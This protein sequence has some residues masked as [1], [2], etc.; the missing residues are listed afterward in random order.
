MAPPIPY[1]YLDQ[2]QG[3]I[4]PLPSPENPEI[5]SIGTHGFRT[6]V[7][8]YVPL[9]AHKCFAAHI[10]GHVALPQDG[11][12]SGW[13]PTHEQ[14]V[15]LKK[16]MKSL[17]QQQLPELANKEYAEN[18]LKSYAVVVCPKRTLFQAGEEKRATGSYIVEAINEF[19]CLPGVKNDEVTDTAHGFV[20][21]HSS[22][23]VN[24]LNFSSGSKEQLSRQD[25]LN[26]RNDL[27]TIEEVQLLAWNRIA[28]E[29]MAAEHGY[30][31]VGTG[32]KRKWS[33][34]FDA[35]R[36]WSILD[37]GS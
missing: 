21:D 23:E 2:G 34:K 22:L 30:A 36:G 3:G 18:F 25:Q 26:S 15:A 13:I 9:A 28:I 16:F 10:D 37:F 4:F 32:R 17:L 31:T 1:L 7:C 6:C 33:F 24:Y 19:F 20:V 12:D 27:T 35:G 29:K 11:V 5:S 8:V 14:G